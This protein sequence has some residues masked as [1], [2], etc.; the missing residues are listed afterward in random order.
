MTIIILNPGTPNTPGVQP[1]RLSRQQNPPRCTRCH[2][3]SSYSQQVPPG[4][5][6]SQGAPGAGATA[7]EPP[8]P[9]RARPRDA[10]LRSLLSSQRPRRSYPG[11]GPM[12]TPLPHV[13]HNKLIIQDCPLG[14]QE[15]KGIDTLL[16]PMQTQLRPPFPDKAFRSHIPVSR[17]Q[18][19]K[20]D[21]IQAILHLYNRNMDTLRDVPHSDRCGILAK[22]SIRLLLP[23]LP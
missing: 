3:P 22:S 9:T 13:Q 7:K 14:F 18:E 1:T 8:T 4:Q 21:T 15:N 5:Q 10:S 20:N 11:P 19:A 16:T 2:H 12:G 23:P 6:C 17:K